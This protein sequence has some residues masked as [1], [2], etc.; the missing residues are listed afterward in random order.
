MIYI[1]SWSQTQVTTWIWDWHLKLGAGHGLV[2]WSPQ[3]VGS[4]TISL[5]FRIMLNC[6]TPSWGQR[7]S[8]WWCGEAPPHT[9]NMLE[10]GIEPK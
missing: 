1:A 4:D 8:Y 10:L 7:T 2:R 6:G 5:H 9:H 3:P